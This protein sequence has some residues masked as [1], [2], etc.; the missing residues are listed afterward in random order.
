MHE[1]A[2]AHANIYRHAYHREG[3]FCKKSIRKLHVLFIN[4]LPFNSVLK[5]NPHPVSIQKTWSLAA[6]IV[7]SGL[8]TQNTLEIVSTFSTLE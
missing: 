6:G 1:C 7:F 4:E 2:Q 8:P 3:D 5:G